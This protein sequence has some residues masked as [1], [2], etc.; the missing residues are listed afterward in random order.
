MDWMQ[1]SQWNGLDVIRSNRLGIS[2][3]MKNFYSNFY[4][5]SKIGSVIN[6][7][8][9]I[10]FFFHHDNK[11]YQKQIL[12]YSFIYEIY[13]WSKLAQNERNKKESQLKIKYF[14]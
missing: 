11:S 4:F 1:G 3:V 2:F 9:I 8:I 12:F 6:W 10:K 13:A 7:I 14:P 5:I